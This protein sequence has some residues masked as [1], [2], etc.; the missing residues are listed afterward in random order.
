[1]VPKKLSELT[2]FEYSTLL[3]AGVLKSIYPESS[4]NFEK[5]C[6]KSADNEL[7]RGFD[8]DIEK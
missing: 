1:M 3:N 7:G 8:N 5:D 4:G 6:Q 2:Y